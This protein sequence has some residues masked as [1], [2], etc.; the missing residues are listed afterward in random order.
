LVTGLSNNL[1]W[2]LNSSFTLI[3]VVTWG[4]PWFI[5][6]LYL[7]DALSFRET[8]VAIVISGLIYVPLCWY[9][10][11]MSP[12]LHRI[13]YGSHQHDFA[14]T[15]RA[16]GYRPMV[17][18]Q[19]GLM[20][21]AWMMSASLVGVWLWLS[22]AARRICG[23]PLV[24]LLV[25]LVGTTILCK[26]LGA[27]ALLGAG[28]AAL[29]AIKYFR[30]TGVLVVLAVLPVLFLTARII[31]RRA[32][33]PLLDLATMVNPERAE[34]LQYRLV[35]EDILM[36]KALQQPLLGWGWGRGRVKDAYGNDRAVTD[37][38]WIIYLGAYGLVGLGALY[39]ALL[40]P[41]VLVARRVR[42]LGARSETLAPVL[43]L[44]AIA[45]LFAIDTIPNSMI[46]RFF[47]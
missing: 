19:H 21:A 46:N 40:L 31:D 27:L 18:M 16:G 15:V 20:V 12:Q 6:R 23:V 5:G 8:A 38:M 34:S 35:N 11:V 29:L 26:S 4:M 13:V 33:D 47:H 2:R 32:G 9:E 44:C 41:P 7:T 36:E 37:G 30:W 39:G 1:D 42:K 17:F 22:G 3:Q 24:W 45:I 10:L 14:Q 25:P 43:S 28:I